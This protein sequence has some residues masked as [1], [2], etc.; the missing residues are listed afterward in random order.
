LINV[1]LEN[2]VH[3]APDARGDRDAG[4]SEPGL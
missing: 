4:H 1:Q 2:L 3:V